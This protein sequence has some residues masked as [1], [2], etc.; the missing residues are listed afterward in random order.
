VHAVGVSPKT[1]REREE[2]HGLSISASTLT[3]VYGS[4]KQSH[5][6]MLFM[7]FNYASC[8]CVLLFLSLCDHYVTHAVVGP[9]RAVG[10]LL[11]Q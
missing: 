4:S 3:H 8:L 7:L 1:G 2:G 5:N 10:K 6:G 9:V 11:G